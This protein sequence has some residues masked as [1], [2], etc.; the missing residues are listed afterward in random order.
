MTI[1]SF[2]CTSS[3]G[4]RERKVLRFRRTSTREMFLCFALFPLSFTSTKRP[5]SRNC[6]SLKENCAPTHTSTHRGTCFLDNY[7]NN[8]NFVRH[9][10][11][12]TFVVLTSRSGLYRAKC[13]RMRGF[14]ALI[15]TYRVSRSNLAICRIT[16]LT[17]PENDEA[18]ASER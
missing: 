14:V 13:L 12:H 1:R 6:S 15:T 2:S 5:D 3:R 17:V 9:G 7:H 18:R 8:N 10:I 4:K 11:V 16:M